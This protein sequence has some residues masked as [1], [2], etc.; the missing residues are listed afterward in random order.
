MERRQSQRN[1]RAPARLQ[2]DGRADRQAE[3][4]RRRRGQRE[5][6]QDE[7]RR[8]T[9]EQQE[10]FRQD[11]LRREMQIWADWTKTNFRCSQANFK[12]EIKKRL[13]LLIYAMAMQCP[14]DLA[15]G[16]R[17]EEETI[18]DWNRAFTEEILQL[19]PGNPNWSNDEQEI[20]LEHRPEFLRRRNNHFIFKLAKTFLDVDGHRWIM[21][22]LDRAFLTDEL[23]VKLALFIDRRYDALDHGFI[24]GEVRL[25]LKDLMLTLT[26]LNLYCSK[27]REMMPEQTLKYHVQKHHSTLF[28]IDYQQFLTNTDRD[29]QFLSFVT[30]M[31]TADHFIE[32]V[33]RNYESF[34]EPAESLAL[35]GK[36]SQGLDLETQ[37]IDP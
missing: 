2:I 9:P 27:C 17:P 26:S 10:A 1:R 20:L 24:A 37:R 16:T 12:A 8:L 21:S 28:S 23:L 7:A 11:A 35:N 33:L 14:T 5:E 3:Y 13:P 4:E 6:A 34:W 36:D 30:R 18:Q 19:L 22:H 15:H 25:L 32:N 29:R 31:P